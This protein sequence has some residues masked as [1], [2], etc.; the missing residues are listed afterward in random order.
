MTRFLFILLALLSTT[1]IAQD[2]GNLPHMTSGG[3]AAA[4]DWCPPGDCPFEAIWRHEETSGTRANDTDTL[5]GSAGNLTDNNTVQ[6]STTA[7]EGVN[8]DTMD[9]ANNEYLSCTDANCGGL[10][11]LDVRN[12][13]SL[14]FGFWLQGSVASGGTTPFPV[15]KSYTAASDASWA[16]FGIVSTPRV[17]RV[18]DNVGDLCQAAAAAP[19]A[20][21]FIHYT[22]DF[23]AEGNS[24]NGTLITWLDS[25]AAATTNCASDIDEINTTDPFQIHDLTTVREYNMDEIDETYVIK[26]H[27]S[28]AEICR[29][30]SCTIAGDH[31]KC[32]PANMTE[33]APCVNDED[34]GGGTGGLCSNGQCKGRNDE[35][36]NCTLPACNAEPPDRFPDTD[37]FERSAIANAWEQ[38][39]F[40]DGD[41]CEITGS[42]DLRSSG[43]NTNDIACMWRPGPVDTVG[44]ACGQLSGSATNGNYAGVCVGMRD[45]N[46]DDAVCCY[47]LAEGGA[48]DTE[49]VAWQD[50]TLSIIN[51]YENSNVGVGEWIGIERKDNDTF[52]CYLS[53]DGT[54]WGT[55]LGDETVSGIPLRGH[56]GAFFRDQ[57]LTLE[58]WE[59]GNGTLPTTNA[60]GSSANEH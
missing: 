45:G 5:L 38:M 40:D 1:V 20:N 36:S 58:V 16:I 31:C 4:L 21:T 22:C 39:T 54:T 35:C 56:P 26:T 49:M 15:A 44:Y 52:E 50:G 41:S 33:Y 18:T 59:G 60:C 25:S 10:H 46:D 14:T 24:G 53:T 13:Q 6:N 23:N 42:S 47:I 7:Q 48:D 37:A 27:M 43:N 28:S 19:A 8:A 12:D 17:C 29:I 11:Y 30:C 3:P 57:A 55:G 9:P 32:N 51:T 2:W 34:C